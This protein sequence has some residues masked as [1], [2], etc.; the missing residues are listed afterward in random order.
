[1]R[2]GVVA[3]LSIA[4]ASVFV[5]LSVHSP[6]Y[7]SRVG[8][9]ALQQQREPTSYYISDGQG[10]P[11]YEQADR[12]LAVLAFDAWSRESGNRLKFVR[13][14]EEDKALLRLRWISSADGLFG[15]AQRIYVDGKP[16]AVVFVSPATAGL[17]EPLASTVSRDRLLRDSIVY[18]T[19][20]HEI[21]HAL[22]LQHTRNFEDIMY[23]FGYGGDI[24]QY[25]SRYRSKL[26]SR[27]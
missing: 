11:G 9:G 19:C 25:F 1:M 15:E 24:V 7:F 17:G 21:G 23:Y 2:L 18:L 20:V 6:E 10:V 14:G 5:A 8:L 3:I 13:A 27:E 12:D 16:G 22:G 4:C 26:K